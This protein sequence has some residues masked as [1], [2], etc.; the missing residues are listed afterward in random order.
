MTAGKKFFE[1]VREKRAAAKGA[2]AHEVQKMG[3]ECGINLP[4]CGSLAYV[5][6]SALPANVPH[7]S[8]REI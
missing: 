5:M 3:R 7:I 2:S 8:R 4:L 1:C 6:Q